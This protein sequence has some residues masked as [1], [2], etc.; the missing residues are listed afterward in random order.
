MQNKAS[1]RIN[2]LL[3]HTLT[4]SPLL[5]VFIVRFTAVKSGTY[6]FNALIAIASIIVLLEAFKNNRLRVPIYLRYLF[7]FCVY[8]VFSDIF[9][10]DKAFT[11]MYFFKN[12]L[13]FGFLAALVIENTDFHSGYMR[14]LT[15]LLKTIFWLSIVAILIQQFVDY[16]FMLN[17]NALEETEAADEMERRLSSIYSYLGGP[18][19]AGLTV[20]PVLSILVAE[21][22]KRKKPVFSLYIA[23]AIFSLLNKSRWVLINL[24]L[25]IFSKFNIRKLSLVQ[26]F[27]IVASIVIASVA[28]LYVLRYFDFDI[29][30]FVAQRLLETNH[31]GLQEGAASSRLLAFE[32][33]GQVYTEHPI[34]GKGNL[35]WGEG[36]KGDKALSL[37]LRGRSSQIHV[38]YLSLLYWYGLLG[39]IPFIC[40][41]YTMMGRMRS[42][43]K[44]FNYWGPFWGMMGLVFAN[45]T[46]VFFHLNVPGLLLCLVYSRYYEQL[47]N[48]ILVTRSSEEQEATTD[49]TGNHTEPTIQP[50]YAL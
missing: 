22:A 36:A 23:G 32:I 47:G 35:N 18:L 12:Q 1:N 39:A 11:F 48:R 41:L 17:P 30:E 8:T 25:T 34:I 38:G 43:A 9:L 6:V 3:V 5:S 42:V 14:K 26:V 24:V 49:S 13:F 2:L 16:N 27:K 28:T 29:D 50:D 31:G 45:L 15:K 21:N 7:I 10:A 20:I 19:Y 37:L 44:K 46:L 40:F 33:F 4:L